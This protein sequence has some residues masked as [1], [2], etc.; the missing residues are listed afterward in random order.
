ML[1]SIQEHISINIIFFPSVSF[2]SSIQF[3]SIA[4][5]I[6]SRI[7]VS[8]V[9]TK[10]LTHSFDTIC[11]DSRHSY[12][13]SCSHQL[14]IIAFCLFIFFFFWLIHEIFQTVC[15]VIWMF[16][17]SVYAMEHAYAHKMKCNAIN[18]KHKLNTAQYTLCDSESINS[19][20]DPVNVWIKTK[21]SWRKRKNSSR[22]E[23]AERTW[24]NSNCDNDN[25]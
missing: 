10:T 13:L 16:W 23:R 17:F 25:T 5:N 6:A 9:I 14:L 7:K 18:I 2:F 22:F 8:Q 24:F 19:K 3:Y 21:L 4:N 1:C 20:A 12:A 11:P 15:T